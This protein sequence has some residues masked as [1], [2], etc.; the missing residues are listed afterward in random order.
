MVQSPGRRGTELGGSPL[1]E[2]SQKLGGFHSGGR[3]SSCTGAF[4][5]KSHWS[6]P[7]SGFGQ[8]NKSGLEGLGKQLVSTGGSGTAALGSL[9]HDVIFETVQHSLLNFF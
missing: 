9:V 1:E 4:P 7:M 8:Q 3:H 6:V 2:L 5:A